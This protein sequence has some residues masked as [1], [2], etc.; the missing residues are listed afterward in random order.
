MCH[1]PGP[2]ELPDRTRDEANA[3]TA[4]VPADELGKGRGCNGGRNHR[5]GKVVGRSKG[6][7]ALYFIGGDRHVRGRLRDLI[8]EGGGGSDAKGIDRGGRDESN[9]SAVVAVAT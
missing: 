7:G 3:E 8:G 5:D 2:H 1:K 6:L 4:P 9:G